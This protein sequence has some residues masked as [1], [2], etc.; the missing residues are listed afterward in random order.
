TRAP[1]SF[2]RLLGRCS[3]TLTPTGLTLYCPIR[4]RPP[5][6]RRQT[7][8]PEGPRASPYP[9]GVAAGA[10]TLLSRKR[11]GRPVRGAPLHQRTV[12][13][14]RAALSHLQWRHA[15]DAP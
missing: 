4:G 2:K 15:A 8:D 5:P 10:T 11:C 7:R 9:G 1:A 3:P 13:T 14:R 12:L 6:R